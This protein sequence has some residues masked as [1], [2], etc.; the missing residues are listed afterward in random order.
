M[1]KLLYHDVRNRFGLS[2]NLAIQAIRRVCDNRKAAHTNK[3][4][5]VEFDATSIPYDARIFSLRE[6]DWTVSLT[7]LYGRERLALMA[8]SYQRDKLAGRAPKAA[9]L[10]LH[11]DGSYTIHIQIEVPTEPP[12]LTDKAIGVDLGRTD[13]AYTSRGK[14]WSGEQIRRVRDRY[15]R[16]RAALERKATKG[17]RSTRRRCR[18]LLRRLS[19]RERSD[20]SGKPTTRSATTLWRPPKAK[21]PWWYSKT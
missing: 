2:A 4:K 11:R 7:L 21:V 12:V 18:G 16:L 5:V 14:S 19:G 15:S 20:S 10:C 17:T 3:S 8:G 1:Q 6:A 9:Q 13:L